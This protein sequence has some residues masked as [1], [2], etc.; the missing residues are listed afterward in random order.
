M[1]ADLKISEKFDESA[2]SLEINVISKEIKIFLKTI[3][4]MSKSCIPLLRFNF[5]ISLRTAVSI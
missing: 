5:L 3:T 4:G 1:S 2:V